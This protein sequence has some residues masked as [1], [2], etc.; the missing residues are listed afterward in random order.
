MLGLYNMG[1]G[2][3]YIQCRDAIIT[4]REV[5]ELRSVSLH[6]PHYITVYGEELVFTDAA[7]GI[8]LWTVQCHKDYLERTITRLMRRYYDEEERTTALKD[9]GRVD[10]YD[11]YAEIHGMLED[12]PAPFVLKCGSADVI[13]IC[14]EWSAKAMA[15]RARVEE[16]RKVWERFQ[17]T[18]CPCSYVWFM[19]EL[20]GLRCWKTSTPASE[21]EEQ[22]R[23]R[24][25]KFGG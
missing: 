14:S 8:T 7:Y 12:C 16:D 11:K 19:E 4:V 15:D 3:Q 6:T 13:S 22:L 9:A 1:N 20:N 10:L 18:D 17:N 23:S 2:L 5:G 21:L 25:K 24:I